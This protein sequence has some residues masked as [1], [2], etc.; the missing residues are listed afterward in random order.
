MAGFVLEMG[1]LAPGA[2]QVRAEAG[3]AEL[4]LSETQWPRPIVG[5]LD[6]ERSGERVSIRGTLE[7]SAQLECARCLKPYTLSLTV[8]FEVFAERSGMGHRLE[9]EELERGDYMKFHDGRQLDVREDA[10]ETLLLE[11]PIAPHCREGCRG[12]CPRCGADL[13][14]GPCACQVQE[15]GQKSDNL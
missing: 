2:S 6:V 12:L 10:R 3:A 15:A 14:E 8:P 1:T 4:G 11:L 5:N 13:N 9:E 7:T